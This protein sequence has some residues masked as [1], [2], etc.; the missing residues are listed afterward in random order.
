MEKDREEKWITIRFLLEKILIEIFALGLVAFVVYTV[1]KEM[2]DVDL[3]LLIN[4]ILKPF[5]TDNVIF[6]MLV[7][8]IGI[9]T[10]IFYKRYKFLEFLDFL[11]QLKMEYENPKARIERCIAGV[12]G[13]I[14][15]L[16]FKAD[17]LKSFSPIPIIIL[18]IGRLFEKG[19]VFN[20]NS[21]SLV[22]LAT[23]LFYF[24]WLIYIYNKFSV[25]RRE[26]ALYEKSL[27]EIENPDCFYKKNSD[28]ISPYRNVNI[29]R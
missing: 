22:V 12:N 7:T 29:N 26:L 2:Y 4:S 10:K 15:S 19:T 21:Y 13:K 20:L 25:A 28:L 6:I 9:I 24:W 14:D 1:I 8:T 18:F 17:I 27:I 3:I 23:V 5:P 11:N 16:K